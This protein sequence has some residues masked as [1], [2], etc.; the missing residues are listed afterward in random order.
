MIGADDWSFVTDWSTGG[1]GVINVMNDPPGIKGV[2]VAGGVSEISQVTET[3]FAS[4]NF[5]SRHRTPRTGQVVLF[6]NMQGFAAAVELVGITISPDGEPGTELTAKYKILT[7]G[8]RNFS[9]QA[10]Q[11]FASIRSSAMEVLETLEE[12][13]PEPFIEN[14]GIGIGHNNPPDDYA[15]DYFDHAELK[16]SIAA[17][18]NEAK[19]GEIATS[20]SEKAKTLILTGLAKVKTWI[21][22]HAKLI[23]EGFFTQLGGS[24]ALVLTGLGA[25]ALLAGK[26]DN[27]LSLISSLY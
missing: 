16:S 10:D 19:I 2:A 22:K 17:L 1:A 11:I 7:D 3:V 24:L 13:Q 14:K 26:L 27:L 8:G 20:T 18:A 5:T 15:L 9:V 4:A 12:L 6:E 23:E 21:A 25:A